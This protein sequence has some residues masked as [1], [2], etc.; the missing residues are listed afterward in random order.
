MMETRLV[1]A[2]LL[3]ALMIAAAAS[4]IVVTMRKRRKVRMMRQGHGSYRVNKGS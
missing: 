3:I 4:I 2:Y 1:I